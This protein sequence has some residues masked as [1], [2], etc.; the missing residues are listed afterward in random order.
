MSHYFLQQ[1]IKKIINMPDYSSSNINPHPK[2]YNKDLAEA[3]AY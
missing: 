2:I 3:Q 1:Y